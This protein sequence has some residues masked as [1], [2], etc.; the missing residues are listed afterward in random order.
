MANGNKS[1][2]WTC[3]FSRLEKDNFKHEYQQCWSQNHMLDVWLFKLYFYPIFYHSKFVVVY[4]NSLSNA[5]IFLSVGH[6][7]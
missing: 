3:T 2:M 7:Y 1:E 6:N 5:S 4:P